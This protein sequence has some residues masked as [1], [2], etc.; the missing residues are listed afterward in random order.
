[1]AKYYNTT[2]GPLAASLSSGA[3]IAI[4]PKSW[5]AIDA[6]DE[7]SPG[8]APLIRKGF[9]VRSKLTEQPVVS[10]PIVADSITPEVVDKD[11]LTAKAVE[12][13]G[14]TKGETKKK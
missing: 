12:I 7:G 13:K 1:M 6:G 8:L 11:S 3:S 2:R 4:P 10:E 5:T 14:D 9:L